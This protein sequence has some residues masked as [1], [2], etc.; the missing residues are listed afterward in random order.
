[1]NFISYVEE[2]KTMARMENLAIVRQDIDKADVKDKINNFIE[3]W[4]CF[5]AE[6]VKEQI[7]TN[8]LVAA[9]FAKD[10]AKQNI[11]EKAI[12][13]LIGADK[14]MPASG[15]N[16]IRF[17]STG[18]IV[19]SAVAGASKSVDF[20]IDGV[21]Y[22]QKYTMEAG[23][24]QDNQYHDVIEFLEKGSILYKVGAIVDG[25]Y[26]E[27]GRRNTLIDY[28]KNNPNVVILSMDDIKQYEG[29]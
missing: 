13:S 7:L 6:Q 10:P 18:E 22:T 27:D 1:M 25:Y 2:L 28:F 5:T 19:H 23:G 20:F 16:C 14:K 24:A 21:Y 11:A 8:D 9:Q 26:W 29:E 12:M 4:P 3:R 15:R 17:T